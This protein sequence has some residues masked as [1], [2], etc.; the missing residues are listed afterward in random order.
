MNDERFRIERGAHVGHRLEL[1][2]FHRDVFRRIFRTGATGRD[3]RRDSFALPTDAVCRDRALWRRFQAFQMREHANPRRDDGS[4]LLARHDGDNA[5]R[6]LGRAGIN[7][8]DPGM[9]MR[10]AQEHDMCH[11]R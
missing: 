7:S 5:R 4:K 1:L 3:H 2:V 8:R 6:L 11:A 10:R 9:C